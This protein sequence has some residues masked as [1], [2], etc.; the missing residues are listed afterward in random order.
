[1]SNAYC[2]T[3]PNPTIRSRCC[4]SNFT[5]AQRVHIF[6]NDPAMSDPVNGPCC[7]RSGLSTFRSIVQKTLIFYSK[8]QCV[9]VGMTTFSSYLTWPSKL[10]WKHRR[11][12]SLGDTCILGLRAAGR[13]RRAVYIPGI[14]M[15]S[16]A[17]APLYGVSRSLSSLIR[18]N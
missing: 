6:C 15:Y 14:Y 7:A 17:A 16:A 9:H 1:M 3:L 13:P 8:H 5:L 18:A 11:P 4:P 2:Y 12:V 10:P